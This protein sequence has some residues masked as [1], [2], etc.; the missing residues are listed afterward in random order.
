M[1]HTFTL[2]NHTFT[3]VNYAMRIRWMALTPGV[4]GMISFSTLGGKKPSS[5]RGFASRGWWFVFPLGL[6][7]LSSPRPQVWMP[8]T[9]IQ[10]TT[11]R[12]TRQFVIFRQVLAI[13][14]KFRQ[15]YTRQLRQVWTR[16]TRLTRLYKTFFSK[17]ETTHNTTHTTQQIKSLEARVDYSR[18]KSAV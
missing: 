17:I 18:L 15:D 6:K 1:N 7:N 16:F 3:L 5:P 14:N 4:S 10:V 12:F 2:V 9:T 8:H 11:R 13:L